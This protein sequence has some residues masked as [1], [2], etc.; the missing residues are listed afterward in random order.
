[1]LKQH[2]IAE[3][4]HFLT[5]TK[6]RKNVKSLVTPSLLRMSLHL[7]ENLPASRD[8][9]LDYF[10]L[11]ADV[12]VQSY[13]EPEQKADQ[14]SDGRT[15]GG[16]RAINSPNTSTSLA[17]GS[18]DSASSPSSSGNGDGGKG[19]AFASEE[20]L[21]NCFDQIEPVI[22]NIIQNNPTGWSA[23]VATWSLDLLG[24][25]TQSYG[26]HNLPLSVACNYW[27]KC[28][29]MRTLLNLICLSL[30]K[31]NLDEAESYVETF[32]SKYLSY[33]FKILFSINNCIT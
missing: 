29:T 3:F 2:I 9:I 6:D 12:S 30:S 20:F 32:F 4:N 23:I 33:C 16:Q 21:Q 22:T 26:R 25:L 13:V 7:L 24:T 31:L 14:R 15:S 10:T 5:T 17:H 18:N 19:G 1:M 11:V 28:S 27:M 8:V